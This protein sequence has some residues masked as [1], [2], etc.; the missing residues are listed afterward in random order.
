MVTPSPYV[1]Y[2]TFPHTGFLC[3]FDRYNP[4]T[5]WDVV[6]HWS[7]GFFFIA[8][9]MA[10]ALEHQKQESYSEG[11]G[12]GVSVGYADNNISS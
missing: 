7:S 2:R 12:H 11:Y 1:G 8:C 9:A 6:D 4:E 3:S 10:G 5:D